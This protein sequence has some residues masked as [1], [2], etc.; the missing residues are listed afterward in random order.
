MIRRSLWWQLL[1]IG[2]NIGRGASGD[3]IRFIAL[4]L[5]SATL[6]LI[7][8]TAVAAVA[9]VDARDGVERTRGPLF[10]D[11]GEPA[12]ALWR[13]EFDTVDQVQHSVVF[14]EPL[15][16]SAAPPPGLPRWPARGEAYLSPE[17]LRL[18]A[19]ENISARYGHLAG[20][21][22]R[23][24]LASPGERI[25]YVRPP[26][27]NLRSDDWFKITGFGQAVGLGEAQAARPLS[28]FLDALIGLLAVPAV[29]LLVVAARCGSTARDRR[30]ALLQALGGLARHR[31]VV[32]LGEAALPATAGAC[33][34]AVP[35]LT[36]M[37]VDIRIPGTGYL[38]GSTDL[39]AVWWTIPAVVLATVLITLTAVVMLDRV[40]RAGKTTRPRSFSGPVPRWR[41]VLCAVMFAVEAV[42]GFVDGDVGFYLYL[43]GALGVLAT[44]PSVAAALSRGLGERIAAFGRRR[45]RPAPLTAGRWI[46]AHPGVVTRLAVAVII[47][48]GLITQVQVWHSR[49]SEPE[50]EA[51]ATEKRVGGGVLLVSAE[52]D[53]TPAQISAFAGHLPP[54]YT[55]LGLHT[56]ENSPTTAVAPCPALRSVHLTCPTTSTALRTGEGDTRVQELHRWQGKQ[57]GQMIVRTGSITGS[58]LD[59]LAVLSAPET[60]SQTTPVKQAAYATL[61]LPKVDQLGAD[62]LISAKSDS[63]MARWL[64]LFGVCGMLIL[65]LAAAVSAAAEF[66]RFSP[67]LMPL[68]IQT[69]GH[70]I[71][72]SI[73]LWNLAVP[74]TLATLIGTAVTAWQ[75]LHFIAVVDEGT[76]SW[77]TLAI[78]T[79]TGTLLAFAIALAGGLSATRAAPRWR[80]TGD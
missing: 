62:S 13:V 80:P 59:A 11:D 54:A 23:N 18:G 34:G 73:A 58:K 66:L 79:T 25:A 1:R 36:A 19:P 70:R 57:N 38:I 5:A 68:T 31:A 3:R 63:Q 71:F 64:V 49:L 60:G 9:V 61:P 16:A 56:P 69:D 74:L 26:H 41:L 15:T 47:G 32:N 43:T 76:F 52:T 48:L 42:S 53:L 44:L 22:Q 39:R 21:V 6:A 8:S 28:M 33:L 72:I 14:V 65:M 29:A 27:P 35:I 10:A 40:D 50:K 77:E 55:I 12:T 46:V 75:G 20:L 4:L 17:L 37:I 24:G 67:A 78:A 30:S 7:A 51:V 45:G 2:W